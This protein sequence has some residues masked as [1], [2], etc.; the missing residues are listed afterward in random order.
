MQKISMIK[1]TSKAE[2]K[3]SCLMLSNLDVDKAKKMYD[4]LVSDMS[5][6]PEIPPAQKSFIAN[7]GEQANGVLEWFRENG[8]VFSQ[9]WDFVQRII[10]TRKG[11]VVPPAEPLPPINP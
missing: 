10:A 5:E 4:F 8:D 11:T 3:Q 2:L 6:I 9:G 7:F 1:P